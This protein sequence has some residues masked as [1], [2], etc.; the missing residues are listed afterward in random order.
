HFFRATLCGK[1]G[2]LKEMAGLLNPM[3]DGASKILGRLFSIFRKSFAYGMVGSAFVTGAVAGGLALNVRGTIVFAVCMAIGA[4]VAVLV[5]TWWP[6]LTASVWTLWPAAV[7]ANPMFL[8][9]AGYSL[10]HYECFLGKAAGWDCIFV[11]LGPLLCELCLLPPI[12][13]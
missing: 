8:L 2:P 6:K 13:G 11:G 9:G 10:D 5:C 12:F 3:V 4:G 7:A 1:I